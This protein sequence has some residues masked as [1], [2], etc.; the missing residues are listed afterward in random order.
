VDPEP[1]PLAVGA[2]RAVAA[3]LPVPDPSLPAAAAALTPEK[4]AMLT[5][6]KGLFFLTNSGSDW[7]GPIYVDN[8]R[9][10][11]PTP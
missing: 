9:V 7:A 10:V 11:V 1:K 2:A 8:L 5:N 3:L 4:A 6:V